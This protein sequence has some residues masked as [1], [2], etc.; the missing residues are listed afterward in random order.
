MHVQS[1]ANCIN[2]V[3]RISLKQAL[4]DQDADFRFA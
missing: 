2:V 4:S 1:I 3:T